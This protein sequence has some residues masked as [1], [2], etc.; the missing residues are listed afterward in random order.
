MQQLEFDGEVSNALTTVQKDNFVIVPQATKS[1]YAI[2]EHGDGV[3][4]N[5]CK[6]KRG[7]E[8]KNKIPT[9]K[10]LVSDL[11]VIVEKDEWISYFLLAVVCQ[12]ES[13]I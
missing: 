10:G 11:G 2:A 12:L 13:H 8:Q 6:S 9:L 1:G 4:T 7:V 5:M 3:Y